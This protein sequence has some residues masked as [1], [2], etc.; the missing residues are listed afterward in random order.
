M[1]K[2]LSEFKAFALR[3]NVMDLAVGV[4]IGGA[5]S[6]IVA[7]LTENIISPI[8]G[9]FGGANFDQYMLT[10]GDVQI[11]YGAFITAVIN[12]IIMAFIVFLLVK[13][14]RK[15]GEIKTPKKASPQAPTTKICTYC[16]TEIDI[17][18]TRCPHCT[19]QLE[20]KE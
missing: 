12:F 13:G 11:K 20:E 8:I 4:L 6:G 1:K 9:L 17:K 2:F 14:M 7:S 16:R 3:G 10:L 15:L 18:A 19:S 5:F